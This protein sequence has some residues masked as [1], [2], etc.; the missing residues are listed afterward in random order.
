M[1]V[2]VFGEREVDLLKE[3]LDSGNLSSLGAGPMTRRFEREFAAA[4]GSKHGI[5]MNCAMSVLHA[6]V[7]VAG[8]NAGDE[9]IC[10][11]FCVFGAQACLYANAVPVFVDI[12]PKTWNMD[13]EKIEEKIT[14]RTKALIV[15]HVWGLAAEME[16]IVQVAHKHNLLV[17]EDCAHSLYATHKG[18]NTGTWGDIG[19]FSFQM[20]KQLALGD[21]GMAVTD[22]DELAK[23]LN[24]H[25][26]APTF[27]AVAHGLHYNYRT[28]ELTAAVG[29]A[30][31]ERSRGYIDELIQIAG[32][33]DEAVRECEW[34]E[35]QR[36][37]EESTHTFH[38]WGSTFW[39]D[40]FGISL[41]DLKRVLNEAQCG[42]SVGYTNIP[43]YKH[44]VF[45]SRDA[46]ALNCPAY[47]GD[48]DQYPDGL[49]PVAE[50]ILPRTINAYTFGP[51]DSH[52][53]NAE[54][55]AQA[56]RKLE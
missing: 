22:S 47:E 14:K 55:F 45:T 52:K 12:K 3:V 37:P 17:I 30:Q 19:S 15:T 29:V 24:L 39:G 49:C 28:N 1:P 43:A 38:L 41:D 2:R 27:T 46:H 31:L 4:V 48:G 8:A 21:A 56:I 35:L 23:Q 51:K 42:V 6:S 11:P 34:I 54:K 25:A 36:G 7:M 5:A 20:S 26:G 50:E 44:P 16:R 10:D 53:A 9:V 40:R 18:K 32:Y 33:Y 13:P